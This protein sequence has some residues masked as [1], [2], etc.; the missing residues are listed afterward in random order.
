MLFFFVIATYG[1]ANNNSL[2]GDKLCMTIVYGG[3][4]M[5]PYHNLW[6]LLQWHPFITPTAPTAAPSRA[7]M[8]E[9]DKCLSLEAFQVSLKDIAWHGM[10]TFW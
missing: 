9:H 3:P 8:I 7:K 5:A 6:G 2:L 10:S 1:G 4:T